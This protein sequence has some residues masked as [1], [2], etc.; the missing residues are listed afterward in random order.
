M[1]ARACL[2][3]S[4]ILGVFAQASSSDGCRCFPGDACWPSDREWA[5]FNRS[6]DGQLVTTVPLGAPCHEPNYDAEA[7]DALRQAWLLPEVQ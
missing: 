3:A 6:I 4:A 7:C 1:F 5:R 2:L